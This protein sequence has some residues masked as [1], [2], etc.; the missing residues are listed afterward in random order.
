[1]SKEVAALAVGNDVVQR[2]FTVEVRVGSEGV[3]HRFRDLGDE[4]VGGRETKDA[5]RRSFARVGIGVTGEEITGGDG[6]SGV[7][8]AGNQRGFDATSEQGRH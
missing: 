2:D 8:R 1:M 7:F 6:V 4:T 3:V 5:Q